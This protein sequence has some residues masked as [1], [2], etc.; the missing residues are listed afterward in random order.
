MAIYKGLLKLKNAGGGFDVIYPKTEAQLVTLNSG[1]TVE[2]QINLNIAAIT[3]AQQA[4]DAAQAAADAAQQSA[5]QGNGAAEAAQQAADAAQA[6]ADKAQETADQ[7]VADAAKAQAAADK[8]Q[9]DATQGIGDAADALA[10]AQAAQGTADQAVADAAAA[11]KAADDA[12]AAADEAQKDATLGLEN[13]AKAQAAADAAQQAADKGIEDAA[14]ALAAAQAAQQAADA[15]QQSANKGIEDAAGALAAAQAAQK[16]AD[17]AQ[18]SA[19]QGIA[20]AA[21]AL[22]VANQGVADAAAAQQAANQGIADA[23][24]ALAAAQQAQADADKANNALKAIDDGKNK[25]NGYVQLNS[26]GLVPAEFIPTE[27]KEIKIVDN[28]AGRDALVDK[29]VGLS[30][31][32]KD[33]T[34]DATVAKGGAYYIYDGANFVKTAEAESLDVV[35]NWNA[36]EGKPTTLAGYGITD[37][38]N[39]DMLVDAP[40]ANKVLKLDANGK[41]PADITGNAATANKL[42]AAVNIG[43]NGADVVA[44]A[45]AFDGSQAINIPVVLSDTGVAA[46][47]YTKVQ[48]DAKGRVISASNLLPSDLPEV[49]WNVIVGRPNS[50]VADIDDAVAKKHAHANAAQLDKIGEVDGVMAYNNVKMATQAYAVDAANFAAEHVIMV[51]ATEPTELR[52]NGLWVDI[53]E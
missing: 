43:I 1:V 17:A 11:Q 51:S 42:A 34:A 29:F 7:A 16:A 49:N 23:A 20:D 50:A 36:I 3:A 15:A 6:A 53:S 46:G 39:I 25:A 8:A 2:E 21:A 38:V 9:Q 35:L 41:L 18:E 30:V 45:V 22:G 44:A 52:T 32:V 26:N 10:A 33:A 24:A 28:I 31:Y 14:G 47:T 37:A 12:Q 13:A 48:V 19:N 5:N 27:F 4:A 40:A